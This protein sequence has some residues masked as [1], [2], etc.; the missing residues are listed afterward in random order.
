MLHYLIELAV[1]LLGSYF[2]GACIGCM[3]KKWFGAEDVAVAAP[4]IAAAAVAPAVVARPVVAP[5][6]TFTPP[7]APVVPKPVVVAPVVEAPVVAAPVAAVGKMERPRGISAARGGKADNLQRISGVG[8]KN[9]KVLH[10]LGF[11]HFD[12]IAAWTSE[13]VNWVDDHLKFNGRIKREEW[14]RQARLLAEGKEE[15]FT[16]QYGTGGLRNR[17][18]ATLSGTRTRR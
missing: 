14:I 15:E 7:P 6:P 11:F 3:L 10:T 5:A 4:V 13:Q 2:A 8:P 9:E 17:Q 1:W 12:Q 18:G 16:K